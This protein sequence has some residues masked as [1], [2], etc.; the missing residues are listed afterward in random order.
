MSLRGVTGLSHLGAPKAPRWSRLHGLRSSVGW[1]LVLYLMWASGLSIAYFSSPGRSPLLWASLG[2]SSVLALVVGIRRFRPERRLPWYLLAAAVMSFAAGDLVDNLLTSVSHQNSVFLSAADVFHLAM[3]P[4][5]AAALALFIRSRTPWA[6]LSSLLDALIITGGVGL[7]SWIYLI[8]PFAQSA[9]LTWPQKLVW[10]AYPLGD[11]LLL[12]LLARLLSA[13]GFH[14]LSLRLLTFATCGLL[15]ADVVYSLTRLNGSGAADGRVDGGW[16]LFYVLLGATALHPSMVQMT[17]PLPPRRMGIGRTRLL[18]IAAASLLAPVDG[19]VQQLR[20]GHGDTLHLGASA[21]LFALVTA[22]MWGVVRAQQQGIAREA[23][24]RDA[25]TA[26]VAAVDE[27]LVAKAVR[28]TLSRLTYGQPQLE[29]TVAL[30]AGTEIYSIESEVRAPLATMEFEAVMALKG[31]DPALVDAATLAVLLPGQVGPGSTALV[32]PLRSADSLIGAVLVV[33]DRRQ[34]TLMLDAIGAIGFKVALALERIALA[35]KLQARASEAHFRALIQN[36]SDV[37]LVVGSDNK[38]TY[39]TPSAARVLGYHPSVLARKSLEELLPREDLEQS[40][41]R[42]ERM[43]R[44]GA[45]RVAKIEW[46]LQCADGRWIDAEVVCSNLLDDPDVQGLV[47]T[48]RDVTDRR[49]MERELQHRAFHDSLTSLANRGLYFDRLKD[50]LHRV[51]RTNALVAVLFIDVDEFKAI[52]DSWGHSAGDRVLQRLSRILATSIRAG[53]SAARLGGDEFAL[54]VHGAS[55]AEVEAV[56]RRVLGSLQE[57]MEMD[58]RSLSVRISIGIATSEHSTDAGELLQLADL[59]LYE[60][61]GAHKGTYRIFR[62]EL[63]ANLAD[64][65]DHKDETSVRHAR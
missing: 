32:Q 64:L 25:D 42:L 47:L 18:L 16:L 55:L 45:E 48:I 4:L 2:L 3:Y 39:Q 40:L 36:A 41:S 51:A 26:L 38:I 29:V 10:A 57:P 34:L 56:A 8:E 7:L 21:V 6:D 22:R 33:G 54:L 27:G 20:N 62:E 23:T 37:I 53:D 59:A 65:A 61:K 58:G 1:P 52:N 28:T 24:F 5:C 13:G 19:L 49:K 63:R 14:V 31:F 43:R 9:Q 60:A 11:V 46:Q 30:I 35:R 44:Y 12:A 17:V 15:A 50:A